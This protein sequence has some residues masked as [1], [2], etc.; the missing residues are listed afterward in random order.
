MLALDRGKIRSLT[1]WE[2]RA[3]QQQRDELAE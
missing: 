1:I 3:L 2:E